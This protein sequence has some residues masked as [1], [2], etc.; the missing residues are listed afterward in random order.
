MPLILGGSR[1]WLRQKVSSDFGMTAKVELQLKHKGRLK[2]QKK[3]TKKTGTLKI[4]NFFTFLQSPSHR[5]VIAVAH[6][7]QIRSRST[8]LDYLNIGLI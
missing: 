3:K 5:L 1:W 6:P 8:F 4:G 7:M 2:T